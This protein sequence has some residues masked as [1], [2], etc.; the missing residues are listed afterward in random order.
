MNAC[1]RKEYAKEF[2]EVMAF[3]HSDLDKNTCDSTGDVLNLNS[4]GKYFSDSDS[5]I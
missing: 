2:E 5:M 3:C 1:H 4:R